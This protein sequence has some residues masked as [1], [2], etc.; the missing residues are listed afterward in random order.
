MHNIGAKV[1]GKHRIISYMVAAPLLGRSL[2]TTVSTMFDHI[3]G[4][5]FPPV[6]GHA[7]KDFHLSELRL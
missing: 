6:L 2:N 3:N 7:G 5:R 4:P 1:S